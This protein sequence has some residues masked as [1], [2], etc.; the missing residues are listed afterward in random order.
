MKPV[1]VFPFGQPIN[2]VTQS[3]RGPRRVFVLGVY[4]SAVHARWIGTDRKTRIM[5]LAVASE[6]EIFWTGAGVDD[7]IRKVAIPE[8]AGRLTPA[9]PR[10]NG[11]SGR[12]LDEHYLKP[13]GIARSE[14]WLCDLVPHSCMN[15]R[16][17]R[18]IDRD[19]LPLMRKLNLP[20][21][22][23]PREP[24]YEADWQGL[25][26]RRRRDQIASEIAEASPE[27]LVTL[28][29]A[30]L[31]RFTRH[32]GTRSSLAAYRREYGRLHEA[33]IAGCRLQLLPLAHPRQVAQLGVSSPEWAELHGDWTATLASG[34]L[35]ND[36]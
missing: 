26:D 30:P 21:V 29:D 7:L 25:V 31:R 4:G 19:Y 13:L 36:A 9:A 34:L 22:V 10:M 33:T 14:A 3:S 6:P 15:E 16:Q 35:G 24:R 8:E 28:G 20:E 5:A 27:V 2:T 11:P 23:W 32:F 12:A 17:F 18:A 1:G